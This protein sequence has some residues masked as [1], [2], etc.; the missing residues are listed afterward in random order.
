MVGDGN[1]RTGT[2]AAARALERPR[3]RLVGADRDDLDAVAPVDA[4]ED[5]L[6]VRA[7]AGRE[8]PDPHAASSTG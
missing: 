4:V 2:P 1:A 6:E 5:R 8:D 3:R 7:L